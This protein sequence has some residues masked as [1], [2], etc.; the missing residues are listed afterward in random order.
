[1]LIYWYVDVFSV[2][3]RAKRDGQHYQSNAG[4]VGFVYGIDD[5]CHVN[6]CKLVMDGLM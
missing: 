5:G 4:M 6:V 1:M 3:G 2:M